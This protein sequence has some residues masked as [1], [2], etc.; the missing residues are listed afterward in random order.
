MKFDKKVHYKKDRHCEEWLLGVK[1]SQLVITFSVFKKENEYRQ[2]ISTYNPVLMTSCLKL[3]V[4]IQWVLLWTTT[5]MVL[6][7][8]SRFLRNEGLFHSSLNVLTRVMKVFCCII[9]NILNSYIILS[10][11]WISKMKGYPI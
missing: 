1:L 8:N 9:L 4:A 10:C 7:F 3:S 11:F 6:W 5:F 2:N